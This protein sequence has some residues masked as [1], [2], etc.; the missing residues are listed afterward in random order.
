VTAPEEARILLKK[1]I[2]ELTQMIESILKIPAN[3][4]GTCTI[5]QVVLARHCMQITD[6]LSQA[7]DILNQYRQK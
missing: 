1:A 2:E 5:K 7:I 6:T 4:D 3:P